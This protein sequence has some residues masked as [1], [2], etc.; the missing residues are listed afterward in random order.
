MRKTF[1]LLLFVS[2][3]S[4]GQVLAQDTRIVYSEDFETADDVANWGVFVGAS[5]F[6]ATGQNSSA[7]VASSGALEFTDGGY[8]FLIERAITATV[9]SEYLLTLDIKTA[10]WDDTRTLNVSVIGIDASPKTV[11]ISNITDFTTITIGGT[12]T[13]ATGHIQIAGGNGGGTNNVWVDNITLAVNQSFVLESAYEEVFETMD[14][15]NNW[16]VFTPD[17]VSGS[18]TKTQSSTGGVD[19]TGA[20]ELGDAGFSF[21]MERPITATIGEGYLLTMDVKVD[22]WDPATR[23]IFVTIDG[24]DANPK[25]VSIIN[26]SDFG[27]ITLSGTATGSSGHIRIIGNNGFVT[28]T[29][30][31]DNISVNGI[32]MQGVV[33]DG[34]AWNSGAEPTVEDN[35]IVDGSLSIMGDMGAKNFEVTENGSITVESGASLAIMGTATGD[36]TI[37]RNTTGDAGYSIIGAPIVGADISVLGADYLHTWDG[38]AWAT[39]AGAM[40]PGVGYFVGYD[41]ASPEV[42]LTGALVS[43]DQSTTVSTAGDGFN[44]VANPYAAAISIDA[45]LAG[46]DTNIDGTVYLWNDG[47]ANIAS[48]R[49]GDYVTVN[50]VGTVDLVDLSGVGQNTTAANTDIGSMQGFLVHASVDASSVNFTAAMQTSAPGANADDNFYRKVEQS[51]LK[52]ALS[53]AHYNEVLFGFRSD[54][55]EGVDRLFDAVKRVGNDN[56]AFYSTIES[57]KFAIQGLPELNGNRSIS[58]GYDVK[59]AGIYELAIKD[60]QGIPA[61][62]H[63]VAKYNGISYDLSKEAASLNLASGKGIVE[64]TLTSSVLSVDLQSTFKV[65]N[66]GRQLNIQVASSIENANIQIFDLTGRVITTLSEETF[67]NGMWSKPIDLRRGDVYILKVQ[68]S[69]GMLTKKFIY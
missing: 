23:S 67:T 24:I 27:T 19:G 44:L 58:L 15:I 63:V 64:L 40:M 56:F 59:E 20:L 26:L 53:G 18:T 66:S 34:T 4:A 17:A 45:F 52:L 22:G 68:S 42:S 43:G 11:N 1:L 47:D 31:I 14:D 48:D 25:Q 50:S 5:G 37:K 2:M 51:T 41:A 13:S 61:D 21:L 60:I 69:E 36:A 30:W 29:V 55:T 62:Y 32:D 12:V 35:V 49:A 38:S 6:T 8:A 65:Y 3:L 28:N 54:A 46:N 16:G 9:G 39:P 57:E 33:W 7:G 10:S